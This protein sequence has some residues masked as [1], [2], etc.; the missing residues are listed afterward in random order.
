MD[1][2]WDEVGRGLLAGGD[3]GF[4]GGSDDLF[5]SVSISRSSDLINFCFVFF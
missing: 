1:E 2:R 4:E 3:V 5:V